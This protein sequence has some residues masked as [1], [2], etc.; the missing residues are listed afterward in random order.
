MTNDIILNDEQQNVY[1]NLIK[2]LQS[3]ENEL[4]L[5]GYAG[6]GKTTLITKFIND[7]II[8]KMVRRIALAAPTHK[9]VG[10]IKNKLFG[11][12]SGATNNTNIIKYMD[13]L[14][15]IFHILNIFFLF[16]KRDFL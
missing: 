8:K 5:I 14:K 6:T 3:D 1:N 13:I 7:I 2:F 4:L 10:I 16:Y 9:A 11:N 15:Y 12:L